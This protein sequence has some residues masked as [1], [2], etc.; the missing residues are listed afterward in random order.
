M[1][2]ETRGPDSTPPL[3]LLSGG[4]TGGHVFPA[5]AVGDE[6]RRRGWRVSFAGNPGGMER[7]LAEEHGVEF[8]PLAA[9]PMVGR[10][11]AGR[12][13]AALTV[14]ASARRARRWIRAHDVA[15]VVGTGGYASAPAVVAARWARRPALLVEPNARAGVA[16]RWLSRFAAAAA[17]AYPET[18]RSLRCPSFLAGVPVRSG[19]FSIAALDPAAPPRLLV[20]GGSQGSQKLNALV[21]E[22]LATVMARLPG[23]TV[24]HQAGARNLTEARLLWERSGAPAGR[25]EVVDFVTEVE[26]EMERAS[27]LL[28]RAGAITLAEICA[29]G[30]GALLMPLGL[31]GGHQA[32]NARQLERAGAAR[33]FEEN[34][35]TPEGLALALVELLGDRDRLVGM[36][37]AA[38]A[39]ARPGAAATIADRVEELARVAR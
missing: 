3:A 32:D 22:A 21:P 7:R 14:A 27:L 6:L 8:V 16:N 38:R 4:G 39:L 20:L 31:A 24:L 19:F 13:R 37:R 25:V 1:T 17:V 33:L 35:A 28:S 34:D 15:A 30:R 5:L 26:R 2:D 12:L 11:A 10:S 9:R 18:A 36:G 23:L 29:A